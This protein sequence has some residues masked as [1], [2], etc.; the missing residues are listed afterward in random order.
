[1]TDSPMHSRLIRALVLFV[2]AGA[3]IYLAALLWSGWGEALKTFSRIG[4]SAI[5]IGAVIASSAV[6]LRFCRWQFALARL[7][8]PLPILFNLRVYLA[9]LALTMSPGKAG[10]T[11][12]TLLLLPRG[13]LAG[14]S[15]GAFLADRLS[16]VLG[17]CALGVMSAWLAGRD[18]NIILI[19]GMGVLLVAVGLRR[20][21]QNGVFAHALHRAVVRIPFIARLGGD[22][23]RCWATLWS[24]PRAIAFSLVAVAAYGLQALVFWGFCRAA[25]LELSAA[26][27]I[28]I[29][30][31]ATLFG[32]ASMVPGGLGTMEAALVL[33]LTAEGATDA[34]AVA[35]AVATRMVTL[36]LGVSIGIA[37]LASILW[38]QTVERGED[39]DN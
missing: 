7:G 35:V 4:G 11:L 34:T 30:T 2:G 28:A 15:L 23:L 21:A 24:A 8:H 17:V 3:A 16:D 1:M 29:F 9:G 27:G 25:E 32:A 19:G 31:S 33:Q 20:T 22:A 6:L 12:R 18:A 26:A 36:W 37:A 13:V 38:R 5:L 39:E 14:Q 10:E